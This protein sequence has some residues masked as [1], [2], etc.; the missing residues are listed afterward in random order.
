MKLLRRHPSAT[1][2]LAAIFVV[3]VAQLVLD[4]VAR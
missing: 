3:E 4:L 2:W 1:A